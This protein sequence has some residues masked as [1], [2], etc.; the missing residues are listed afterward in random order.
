[1]QKEGHYRKKQILRAGQSFTLGELKDE[2]KFDCFLSQSYE[3]LLAFAFQLLGSWN[4]AEDVLQTAFLELWDLVTN[5]LRNPNADALAI[6][7]QLVK[8][9]ALDL[10]SKRPSPFNSEWIREVPAEGHS[11]DDID[12]TSYEGGRADV[13]GI[14][15]AIEKREA[16]L[17]CSNQLQGK[18][19]EAFFLLRQGFSKK[20]I[21][22][23]LGVS[24]ARVSQLLNIAFSQLKRKL[25]EMGYDC[26]E[27]IGVPLKF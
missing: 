19:R 22:K 25:Q 6:S 5:R 15:I 8:R 16:I 10:L 2:R 4:D 11:E 7:Y 17:E 21:A 12:L 24:S 20:E 3:R 14:V 1:M 9:R 27:T 23:N 18:A 13:E 26:N